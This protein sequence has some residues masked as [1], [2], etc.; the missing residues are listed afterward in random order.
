MGLLDMAGESRFLTELRFTG[1]S[2]NATGA[3]TPVAAQGA[4][5]HIAVYFLRVVLTTSTAGYI[6]TFVREATS[7]AMFR[8]AAIG[9]VGA[10]TLV[11]ALDNPWVLST[12]TALQFVSTISA[13]STPGA[14]L[15]VGYRVWTR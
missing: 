6:E 4:G 1:T 12:N 8:S 14:E 7:T 11:Q 2:I 5:T 9:T 13:A 3:T 10:V 15:M